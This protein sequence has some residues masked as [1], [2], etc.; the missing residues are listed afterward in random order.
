MQF[1]CCRI[2]FT[3]QRPD[4]PTGVQVVFILDG[5]VVHLK[6]P[7]KSE[8]FPAAVT[9]PPL[10]QIICMI[11]GVVLFWTPPNEF[12]D[13]K[14]FHVLVRLSTLALSQ[15]ENFDPLRQRCPASESAPRGEKTP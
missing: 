5:D 15:D 11:P 9:T 4:L 8:Y 14:S 12:G 7:A 3:H 13:R 6:F 1:I 10:P 2:I